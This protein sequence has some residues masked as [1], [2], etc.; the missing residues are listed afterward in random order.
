MEYINYCIYCLR[1][2]CLEMDDDQRAKY[3]PEVL[4]ETIECHELSVIE[5][6]W[7]EIESV[8]IRVP[9]CPECYA[10]YG[11]MPQPVYDNELK[12]QCSRKE[13]YRTLLW[14]TR[15]KLEL[16]REQSEAH[17]AHYVREKEK[18]TRDL[19]LTDEE[20]RAR[21]ENLDQY[22]EYQR[23]LGEGMISTC[24]LFRIEEEALGL[25]IHRKIQ[26]LERLLGE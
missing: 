13:Q 26:H 20:I 21:N 1:Q 6:D 11:S 4:C 2:S 14:D 8:T 18:L 23:E 19:A 15:N 12:A 5:E 10:M 7:G 3:F 9:L 22:P 25:N 17:A 24:N 16:F